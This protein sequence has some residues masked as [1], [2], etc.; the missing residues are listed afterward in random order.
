V[1]AALSDAGR[2]RS[3]EVDEPGSQGRFPDGEQT[4]PLRVKDLFRAGNGPGPLASLLQRPTAS[5][6]RGCADFSMS[7]SKGP[8]LEGEIY[9]PLTPFLL[10]LIPPTLLNLLTPSPLPLISFPPLLLSTPAGRPFIF[11]VTPVG[12]RGVC[13]RDAKPDRPTDGSGPRHED[14]GVG[15]PLRESCLARQRE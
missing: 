12:R 13:R 5:W 4:G 11:P 7:M 8:R 9:S 6:G 14:G 15:Q 3:G 10:L 2:S 1:L